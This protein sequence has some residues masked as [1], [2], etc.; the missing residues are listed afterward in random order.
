M[1]H[2]REEEEEEG[3]DGCTRECTTFSLEIF[4]FIDPM[5]RVWGIVVKMFNS[6]F[7]FIREG[8]Q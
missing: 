1:E 4:L 7:C 8:V 5:R 3:D 2:E 6:S